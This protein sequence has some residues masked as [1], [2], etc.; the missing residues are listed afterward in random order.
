MESTSNRSYWPNYWFIIAS[1]SSVIAPVCPQEF[2]LFINVSFEVFGGENN[3]SVDFVAL[4]HT[5]IYTINILN[6]L[7]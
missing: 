1:Q 5:M 3:Y 4:R 6:L 2:N 7:R